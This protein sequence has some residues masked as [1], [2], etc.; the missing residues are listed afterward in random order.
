MPK[1]YRD[2]PI[3]A[4]LLLGGTTLA[5]L[6]V[7]TAS[8]V[9]NP[10]G[11]AAYDGPVGGIKTPSR[12]A[13]SQPARRVEPARKSET[14]DRMSVRDW[15][16]RYDQIRRKAQMTPT[17]RKEASKLVK[18]GLP[19]LLFGEDRSAA[20]TLLA[21]LIAR[22]QAAVAEMRQLPEISQTEDLQDAYLKYFLTAR[23]LFSDYL[24]VQN[25]PLATDKNT[26]ERVITR[27]QKRKEKLGD[28][29]KSAKSLDRRL[30]KEFDL[31]PYRY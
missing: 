8:P 26:G 20:R 13:V 21:K 11:A 9:S 14:E 5:A 2:L 30:R 29:D 10:G 6:A 1:Q 24:R 17:E 25:S 4:R 19:R 12:T 22:Y 18:K 15:F 27:L 31:P 28:L 7:A 16:A 3:S 23:S